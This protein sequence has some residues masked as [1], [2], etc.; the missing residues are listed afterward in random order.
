MAA[1]S[2]AD[3]AFEIVIG[4]FFI[5]FSLTI[6]YPFWNIILTSFSTPDTL[7]YLGF[8]LWMNEWSTKAY[9]FAV[10]TYGNALTGYANSTLRVILGTLTTVIMTILFA[11]PL[12]KRDLPGR[13]LITLYVI[14]TMFFSGGI[15]PLYLLIRR[16]GLMDSRLA[17]IL[18][19][20]TNAF[21]VIVMRNFLMTID[22]AYE[23]SAMM[24]GAS[25]LQVLTRII[26]PLSKPIIAVLIL[27]SAVF[28]WNEWFH[29]LL[30]VKSRDKWVIQFI[31][32]RML[33]R[34]NI[35]VF[36][37]QEFEAEIHLMP[38]E[39]VQAAVTVLTIGPII[40][41]YPFIQKYFAKGVFVGSVKG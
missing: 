20:M 8:R 36:E 5:L 41:V 23:E 39:A 31:M 2:A 30:F 28:H 24:D 13:T 35:V 9:R 29:A 7:N 18:P 3:R 17:L 14:I 21:Y 22:L 4:V 34:I 26:I 27:W 6:L 10:S 15:I 16:L 12:S 1:R 32:R 38:K 11:Y 19:V 37:M 25:Y 33:A 40:L